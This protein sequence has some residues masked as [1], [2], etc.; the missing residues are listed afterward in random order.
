ML[1][2][3]DSRWRRIADLVHHLSV[4]R[5]EQSLTSLN[6]LLQF[7]SKTLV[8]LVNIFKLLDV[9]QIGGTLE[10]KVPLIE[11]TKKK[12]FYLNI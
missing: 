5:V 10:L 9:L 6:L 8:Q 11:L 7:F 2:C 1:L 4:D 3:T 12:I